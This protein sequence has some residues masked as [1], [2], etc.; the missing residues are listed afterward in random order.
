MKISDYYKV[1]EGNTSW[2]K[3]IPS[4]KTFQ[5][6]RTLKKGTKTT[7]FA[8]APVHEAALATALC[9]LCIAAG[10]KYCL[11]VFQIDLIRKKNLVFFS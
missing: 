7:K 9:A 4:S 6:G 10:R 2:G 1:F 5:D 8:L 3:F 11:L